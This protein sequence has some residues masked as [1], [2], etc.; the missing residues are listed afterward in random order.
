MKKLSYILAKGSN[1][2]LAGLLSLLGFS[3]C[4]KAEEAAMYGVPHADFSIKG[5]ITDSKGTLI[6]GIQIR[7]ASTYTGNGQTWLDSI[8]ETSIARNGTFDSRFQCF[9]TNNLR[10][11]TTDIDG[12]ENGSFA[13]DSI[14]IELKG[15]DYKGGEGW[16]SGTVEKDI[17]LVLKEKEKH[18]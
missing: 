4:D 1:L 18:E 11:Y 5:K 3:S 9:P 6:P 15:D 14:D 13:N 2:A 17:T 8:P 16:F 10:V 12:D 7:Y